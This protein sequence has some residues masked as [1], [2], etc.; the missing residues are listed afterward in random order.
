MLMTSLYTTAPRLYLF[1]H[2]SS[3]PETGTKRVSKNMR[4]QL[5]QFP[6]NF[7]NATLQYLDFVPTRKSRDVTKDTGFRL[8]ISASLDGCA[9]CSRDGD[10]VEDWCGANHGET[11]EHNGVTR[12]ERIRFRLLSAKVARASAM[13]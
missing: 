2:L 11:G 12:G 5:F 3:R 6:K 9:Q 13:T 1:A 10:F 4:A 8:R 7:S